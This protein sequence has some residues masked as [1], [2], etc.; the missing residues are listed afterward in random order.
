MQVLQEL[1]ESLSDNDRQSISFCV[2]QGVPVSFKLTM[3]SLEC[4][5]ILS[6]PAIPSIVMSGHV[7]PELKKKGKRT[8]EDRCVL[9]C[10]VCFIALALHFPF[11]Y[12]LYS[13]T[14][15]ALISRL[16]GDKNIIKV[17]ENS[18]PSIP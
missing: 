6:I 3:P 8:K 16:F 2:N 5:R 9:K 15:F 7:W 18:R 13:I 17:R 1:F 14:L 10:S 12:E 4:P 11:M